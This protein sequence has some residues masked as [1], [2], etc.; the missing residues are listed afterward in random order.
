MLRLYTF[1]KDKNKTAAQ[2]IL[3][4]NL[5]ENF[6]LPMSE[7]AYAEFVELQTEIQEL[8]ISLD[9]SQEEDSWTY[10]WGTAK[11]SSSRMYHFAFRSVQPPRPFI[12]LWESKCANNRLNTINILRRKK[13]KIQ[14]NDYTCVLCDLKWE[15]TAFH[16]FFNYQFSKSCCRHLNIH[17]CYQTD[18]FTTFERT[19][20]AHSSPYFM[21]I[22]VIA[23]WQIW[24]QRNNFI[25]I[26]GRPS[27]DNWK[28]GFLEEAKLQ[29]NRL[30]VLGM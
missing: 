17:W 14:G 27:F 30:T 15:E 7:K 1:A 18:F 3:Q 4:T 2:F 11:Y 23:A 5:A 25:F 20:Q 26:R 13:F 21:E 8:Q 9:H 10:I 19:R 28:L 6:H 24:K 29:S 12:W 16:L 22:F